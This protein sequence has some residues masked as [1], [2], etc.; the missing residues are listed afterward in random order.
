[1]DGCKII[2]IRNEELQQ[3]K[4]WWAIPRCALVGGPWLRGTIPSAALF[5]NG[6]RHKHTDSR[7]RWTPALCHTPHAT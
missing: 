4:L 7:P 5:A 1:M 6:E 3:I 2:K